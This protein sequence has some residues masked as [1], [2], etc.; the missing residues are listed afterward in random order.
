MRSD[1]RT[2]VLAKILNV[3]MKECDMQSKANI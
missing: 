1:E 3:N 2:G